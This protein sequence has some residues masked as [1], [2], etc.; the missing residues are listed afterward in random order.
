[1]GLDVYVYKD[2]EFIEVDEIVSDENEYYLLSKSGKRYEEDEFYSLYFNPHFPNQS[3]DIPST[4]FVYKSYDFSMRAGSYGGYNKWRSQLAALVG[5]GEIDKSQEADM[6]AFKCTVGPFINLIRFSDCEG[7]ISSTVSKQLAAE[8]EMYEEQA[9][10]QDVFFYNKYLE[11]KKVFEIAS[12]NG[13]VVF[14]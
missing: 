2:V 4:A 14:A 8:F 12:E 7:V 1:M 10:K 9:K 13:I 11:F 5:Y 3:K 6:N